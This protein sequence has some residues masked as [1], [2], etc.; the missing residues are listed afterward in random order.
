MMRDLGVGHTDVS[1]VIR[2]IESQL[3]IT[4]SSFDTA[5]ST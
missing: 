2:M 3:E 1:S 5:A 4:L